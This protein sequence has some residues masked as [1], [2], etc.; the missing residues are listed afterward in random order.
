MRSIPSRNTNVSPYNSE[1]KRVSFD[2]WTTIKP[3]PRS[4]YSR[5][6][7]AGVARTR[8]YVRPRKAAFLPQAREYRP[9]SGSRGPFATIYNHDP[10][11]PSRAGARRDRISIRHAIDLQKFYRR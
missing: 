3:G 11:G 8:A 1:L 5:V 9:G 7:L 6:G 10:L 2:G 4:C